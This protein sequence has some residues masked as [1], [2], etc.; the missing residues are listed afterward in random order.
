MANIPAQISVDTRRR[1]GWAAFI[2]LVLLSATFLNYANR[3]A[4]TENSQR[5]QVA[6]ET[7]KEGYGYA[8]GMFSLGFA[9]GGLTFG[10]LAD[11]LNVRWLYPVVVV[12]WSLAGIASGMVDTLL[13]LSCAQFTL[14][15]FEA[16]HWP[17]SLRTTQRVFHPA[18]RTLANSVLQSGASLGAVATPLLIVLLLKV[19]PDQWRWAF[20]I[21]GGIG[22]PWAIVWCF[23]VTDDD[24]RREV[25]QTDETSAGI[26]RSEAIR[27]SSF[28]QVLL[29]RRW[30]LLLV[31]VIC[32]NVPWHYVRVWF[33]DTLQEEHGYSPEFVGYFRSIYYLATFFGSL[34]AG[35]LTAWLPR[36]GW[37]V[38]RS[39]MFAFL[40][41]GLMSAMSIVAA[42]LP[43][44]W[45]LL[46]ALLIVAFGSLGVFP[47]YYS[48]NQELSGKH[49]G[50]VGGTL[51]FSTW[52]I[53][54]LV[55]P[56]VGKLLDSYPDVRPYLF[57]S[58]GVGPLLAFFVLLLFW[59]RR[60]T[61][62]VDASRTLATGNS[63]SPQAIGGS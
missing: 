59:G 1:P 6:F 20:F 13:G 10:I 52:M 41:F 29:T 62:A 25:I 46:A 3:F 26:G 43:T 50:K 48:L 57:A 11:W 53:L 15:L 19:D 7:N 35:A 38:H 32:I 39:R 18:H 63:G 37:N 22:I 55:H 21:V 45:W 9:L 34:A 60:Q 2:C 23:S 16:G 5:V 58:V 42:F 28:W 44:G 14:G 33:P 56:A 61:S 4:L 40:L 27:E 36:R 54:A 31:V 51:A 30:W 12:V 24:L 17:C 47:V 49:Q 8:S